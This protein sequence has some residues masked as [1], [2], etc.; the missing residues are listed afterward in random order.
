MAVKTY[1][2]GDYATSNQYVKMRI[3]VIVNSQSVAN[4]TSNVTLKLYFRRTNQGYETYGTGTATGGIDGKTYNQAVS[5]SQKIVYSSG[6]GICLFEKSVTVSHST[7]GSKSLSVTGK[8]SI[9]GANLSSNTQTYTVSL[10]TIPRASSITSSVQFYAGA[11]LPVTISRASSSF[12]HKIEVIAGGT[13][14]R[15]SGLRKTTIVVRQPSKYP[16]KQS[17]RR[18]NICNF[19]MY[20]L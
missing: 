6:N 15:P 8:I 1:T 11:Y 10:P 3:Q 17:F 9:P 16:C 19:K 14:R 20:Y 2:S 12:T 5:P 4:N 18:K 7:N 13:S